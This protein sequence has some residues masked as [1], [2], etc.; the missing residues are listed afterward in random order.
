MIAYQT[1]RYHDV[2]ARYPSISPHKGVLGDSSSGEQDDTFISWSHLPM[3]D[4]HMRDGGVYGPR[5]SNRDVDWL[6]G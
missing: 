1:Q 6:A 3:T 4:T 5:R 2:R